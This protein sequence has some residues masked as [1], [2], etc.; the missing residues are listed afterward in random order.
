MLVAGALGLSAGCRH[1]KQARPAPESPDVALRKAALDRELALLAA[2]D[3]VI[4]KVPALAPRLRPLADDKALHVA[5]LGK[6]T[7]PVSTVAT[8]T[9]LRAL[10]REAAG[11]HG[12]AAVSASRALAPLLA[13][14]A[15]SSSSAVAVL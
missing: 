14:L 9:Q 6:G 7:P 13:S 12:A 1:R 5:A 11:A 8:V 10:E 4:G 2:Y 3:A 15:A